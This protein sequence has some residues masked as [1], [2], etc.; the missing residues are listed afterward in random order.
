MRI[1]DKRP[2][3]GPLEKAS[4]EE[5]HQDWYGRDPWD[6]ATRHANVLLTWY[7]D[8]TKRLSDALPWAK[9]RK[10]DERGAFALVLWR[11]ARE[12]DLLIDHTSL[13]DI[14]ERCDASQSTRLLEERPSARAYRVIQAPERLARGTLRYLSR[15]VEGHLQ[16]VEAHDRSMPAASVGYRVR[17]VIATPGWTFDAWS[18][19]VDDAYTGMRVARN[20][21]MNGPVRISDSVLAKAGHIGLETTPAYDKPAEPAAGD[22]QHP[23]WLQRAH[24]LLARATDLDVAAD[25]FERGGESAGMLDFALRRCADALES[26][27]ETV[28][29]LEREWASASS[30][31][32]PMPH[33]TWES[34]YVPSSLHPWL[35][36]LERLV[37]DLAHLL[38]DLPGA[39]GSGHDP[40]G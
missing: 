13:A 34:L 3:A 38:T 28:R 8:H 37:A 19:S 10:R 23:S 12:R 31:P 4:W 2:S 26:L 32:K 24:H 39:A 5:R 20:L 30:N 29:D 18:Q 40:Q 1:M 25:T 14:L 36:K 17:E 27:Q 21:H 15:I 9:E 35:T 7:L 6:R 22:P 16:A 11:T 33:V